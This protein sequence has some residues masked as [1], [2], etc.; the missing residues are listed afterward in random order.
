MSSP[1]KARQFWA[2]TLAGSSSAKKTFVEDSSWM[3]PFSHAS[4]NNTLITIKA[5][6]KE[7]A[8]KAVTSEDKKSTISELQLKRRYSW[9][10]NCV[11][12][13]WIFF[14]KLNENN[15]NGSLVLTRGFYS[16][17]R[18]YFHIKVNDGSKSYSPETQTVLDVV[19]ALN[20]F[21]LDPEKTKSIVG[22]KVRHLVKSW[23]EKSKGKGPKVINK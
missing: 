15:T 5:G 11:V 9:V 14:K 1:A 22:E 20:L 6:N 18:H 12:I 21:S 17:Q 3:M 23:N 19:T 8:L 10:P 2:S 4:K 13:F 7:Y 16:M